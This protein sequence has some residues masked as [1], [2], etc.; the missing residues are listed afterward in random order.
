[1]SFCSECGKKVSTEDKFCKSCGQ[2]VK[3]DLDPSVSAASKP[4]EA[5]ANEIKYP[6]FNIPDLV[7][8]LE[9]VGSSRDSLSVWQGWLLFSS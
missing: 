3:N 1:M 8:R 9:P 6:Q 2:R 4:S 5:T 7:G